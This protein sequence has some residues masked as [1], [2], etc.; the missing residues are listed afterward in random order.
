MA[1]GVTFSYGVFLPIIQKE[2]GTSKSTTTTWAGSLLASMPLLSGPIGSTLTDRYGCRNCTIVG[3]ILATLGFILS[4]YAISIHMLILAFG[5]ITGF[6]LSLCYVAAVV[7][8]AY[9]FDKR[10]SLAPGLSM[11]GGGIGTFMF[12]P[13][14]SYLIEATSWRV[15]LLVD[16]GCFYLAFASVLSS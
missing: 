7:I 8:V 2:F 3:G 13:L 15:T 12:G 4:Y 1:D 11:C 10:R 9:Y 16:A 14:N 5:V 6:G